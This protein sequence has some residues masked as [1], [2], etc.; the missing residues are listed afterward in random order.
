VG[1]ADIQGFVDHMDHDWRLKMLRLRMDDRA[2]LGLIRKWR[3]AGI[4]EP[5]GRVVHPDTGVPQGGVVSP[6]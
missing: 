6:V 3:N 2:V 4:L 1:E 5:D